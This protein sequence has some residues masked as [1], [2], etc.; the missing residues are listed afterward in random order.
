VQLV[1]TVV[2][3]VM[4]RRV[5]VEQTLVLEAVVLNTVAA[6][7]VAQDCLVLLFLVIQATTQLQLEQV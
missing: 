5:Q 4:V 2:V 3:G 6:V 1:V 7:R